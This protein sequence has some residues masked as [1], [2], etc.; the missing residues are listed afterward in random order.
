[1]ATHLITPN[2]ALDGSSS[3]E[4]SVLRFGGH[5]SRLI[6]ANPLIPRLFEEVSEGVRALPRGGA[7]IGG[8]LVGPK[9]Y[10]GGVLANEIIPIPI[11]YRFGPS[12]RLSSPDLTK[13]E[14]AIAA[15][16]EDPSKTVVG[17]Y[18]SRTRGGAEF[19]DSDQE[20]LLAV[21]LAHAGFATDFH[22]YLVFSPPARAEMAL[23]V[24]VRKGN[25]W[26]DFRTFTC[27][28]TPAGI[29]SDLGSPE[30]E[31]MPEEP[32]ALAPTPEPEPEPLQT[33]EPETAPAEA[34]AVEATAHEA[35]TAEAANG[36]QHEAPHAE[37]M[38]SHNHESVMVEEALPSEHHEPAKADV[39]H[40]NGN[41][42][43]PAKTKTGTRKPRAPKSETAPR[44]RARK[45]AAGATTTTTARKARSTAQAGT[46]ARASH[47]SKTKT[48]AAADPAP[49]LEPKLLL[50]KEP[51]AAVEQL[52]KMGSKLSSRISRRYLLWA[53]ALIAVAALAAGGFL[54]IGKHPQPV[55]PQ[56]APAAAAP[57]PATKQPLALTAER[58]GS[59]LKLSWNGSSPS[60]A[61]ASYGMLI[62]KGKD[63]RRDIALTPD[64][65]RAGSIVY[66]PT[67][68]QVEVELNVVAGEQV[69]KDTLVVFLPH[70]GH[71]IV[72]TA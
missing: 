71:A 8:L 57:A 65:L 47:E 48:H 54:L 1:V 56:V 64:Q 59:D 33:A 51:N 72:T 15:T 30:P 12:F 37:S 29:T 9:G 18:R 60:I 23:G 7:E 70:K 69:T 3:G 62:I 16:H 14:E 45:T 35:G 43:T 4:T 27:H 19:R 40:L 39:E 38:H 25:D 53:A 36:D 55:T 22:Y 52:A 31:E 17:F 32:E 66:T 44:P 28:Q 2:E 10:E 49:V 41:G 6:V 50:K 58:H 34:E 68:D 5:T 20:I 61:R 63:G 13:I 21:E 42:H 11:E 46:T 24:A 67:T 26:S